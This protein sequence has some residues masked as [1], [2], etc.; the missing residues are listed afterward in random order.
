[1]ESSSIELNEAI[2]FSSQE[3]K[4]A[5]M[6]RRCLNARYIIRSRNRE[7]F[8]SL[9]AHH[10]V[11]NR[12]FKQMGARLIVEEAL[13][14]AYVEAIS[15]LEEEMDYRLGRA[16]QLS[17][18]ATLLLLFLRQKRLE[19]Y[20]GEVRHETPWIRREEIREFL[21][22]FSQE[23]EDRKFQ[24]KFEKVLQQFGQYQILLSTAEEGLLE[25][26]PVCDVLMPADDL[27]GLKKRAQDYFEKKGE[28]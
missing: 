26:S 2:A 28:A 22:E 14:L 17:P 19:Y 23:K 11:L 20:S 21:S 3:K 12:F 4:L 25:I 1:M 27:E 13:G 10:E 6:I 9:V 15:E 5:G 8:T 24:Q 7:L 18:L 16:V